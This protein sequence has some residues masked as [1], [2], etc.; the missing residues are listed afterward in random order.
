[1]KMA[2]ALGTSLELYQQCEMGLRRLPVSEIFAARKHL[3]IP[4]QE[5]FTPDGLYISDL[6]KE[7]SCSDI[8]DLI[9]Y[10]SNIEDMGTRR[11][12]IDQ[13]KNASSV[14]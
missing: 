4:I 6:D 13:I 10:F 3:D 9:H 11:T 14:F 8:S 7:I 1:M 5:F 12:F 2:K